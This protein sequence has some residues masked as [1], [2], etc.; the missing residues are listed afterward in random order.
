MFV[1]DI[2]HKLAEKY[3]REKYFSEKRPF[4]ISPGTPKKI[5]AELHPDDFCIDDMKHLKQNELDKCLQLDTAPVPATVDREGYY[6][7]MH[8]AYWLS[9]LLDYKKM[10][11]HCNLHSKCTLLDFGGSSGRVSRH[12]SAY[13]PEI[14]VTVADINRNHVDYINDVFERQNLRGVKI[15]S[16]PSLPFNDNI[17]DIICAFSVFTHI[18][19]YETSWLAELARVLKPGGLAYLTTH[20]E[21]TWEQLSQNQPIYNYIKDHPLFPANYSNGQSMLNRRIVFP[22]ASGND[23]SC[24]IFLHSD[25][26]V[27]NWSKF[28][29]VKQIIHGGH[30]Y[31]DVVILTGF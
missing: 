11:E 31:Q 26:I 23:Y 25:H 22:Y 27:K 16:S 18:D 3:E 28:F 17:F 1:N 30:S 5:Y 14:Q 24:N 20:S 9:G 2:I 12:F 8:F 13:H 4:D 6:P 10:R 21:K 15:S 29:T 19:S 7:E